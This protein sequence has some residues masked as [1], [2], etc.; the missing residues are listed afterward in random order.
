MGKTLL[1]VPGSKTFYGDPRY[2]P[3]GISMIG[4]VLL[5]AGHQVHAL[6]MRFSTVSDEDLIKEIHDFRPEIVG[7]TITNWD[8]LEAVRLAGEIK[9]VLPNSRVIFGGPQASLC[10]TETL[11]YPQV[12]ILV[13]GEGELTILELLEGLERG[14]PLSEIEGISYRDANGNP[15]VTERRPLIKDL[16]HLPL[17]AYELFDPPAYR[18]GG[19]LR[20]GIMS[21]RGCPYQCTFCTGRKVMGRRIRTRPPADVVAE[22]IHWHRKFGITHFC[23]VEDNWLGHR[24]HAIELL[25]ELEKAQ[26]PITY[27]L[28]VGVRGDALTESVC[29]RLKRTGCTILAIGIESV[30]PVVLKLVRKGENLEAITRGIRAAKAAGLFVK[31]YFIVGLP[32]DTR[33]KVEMAVAF[34]R[35][36]KIDMPRFALAQAFPHTEL[37]QW[38]AEHGKFH[39]DPY[40]YV[41]HHTD[42]LHGDAHYDL[43]DFPKDEIWKSYK[44]AHDQA[45]AISFKRALVRR[46]GERVGNILNV[47]NNKISRRL[48]IWTYQHKLLS[49]PK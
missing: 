46:F 41:L 21:T 3:G 2:P 11:L 29:E 31:G 40:E 44:W 6:D 14:R 49:L 28:E 13:L 9:S 32:G 7:F 1:I 43:P 19:E 15:I 47:F 48:A 4:A 34:A 36:E 33:E 35:R 26:L 24:K 27:S 17:P 42:E 38:V 45:E 37:A 25:D 18:A 8:V 5:K 39:H 12:D 16:S 22:M 23:F 30:D 10:P 20:L